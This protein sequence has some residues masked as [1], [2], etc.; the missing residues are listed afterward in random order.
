MSGRKLDGSLELKT[1]RQ[2]KKKF[3]ASS[4]YKQ[5]LN[6]LTKT[7][8]SEMIVNRDVVTTTEHVFSKVLDKWSVTNQ[9]QSG[10]CWCFA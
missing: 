4:E 1:V 2:L 10:R 6:A 8:L 5:R 7:K 9:K 3:S